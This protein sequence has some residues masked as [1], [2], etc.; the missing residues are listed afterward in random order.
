MLLL[1]IDFWAYFSADI[2]EPD[3]A[4]PSV[5]VLLLSRAHLLRDDFTRWLILFQIFVWD[6]S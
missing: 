3:V 2:P 1:L 5:E 6:E 4:S